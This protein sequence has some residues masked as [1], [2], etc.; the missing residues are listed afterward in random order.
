M[1]IAWREND[2][3]VE[4][5]EFDADELR[6]L[7]SDG[8]EIA[9]TAARKIVERHLDRRAT[10]PAWSDGQ[11][12]VIEIVEP[13]AFAGHF[14]V[15][16]SR[17]ERKGAERIGTSARRLT[18]PTPERLRD[19]Q[20]AICRMTQP[21]DVETAYTILGNRYGQEIE[22]TPRAADEAGIEALRR[23][24]DDATL[25]DRGWPVFSKI[26]QCV[27]FLADTTLFN[28]EPVP[29]D[30]LLRSFTD[31]TGYVAQPVSRWDDRECSFLVT[32]VPAD[33]LDDAEAVIEAMLDMVR[34]PALR[35]GR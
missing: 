15:A 23:G 16:V 7:T 32:F 2:G 9:G 18:V 28:G 35:L 33:R 26:H 1:L 17:T 22:N 19:Y 24:Y 11:G 25:H 21:E 29:N 4:H 6:R 3:S 27:G 5:I 14:G 20:N 30:D 34:P 12:P 10:W 8:D 31:L 13:A